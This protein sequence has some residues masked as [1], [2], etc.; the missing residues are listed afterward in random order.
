MRSRE[1]LCAA[2]VTDDR[3]LTIVADLLGE[4]TYGLS[5]VRVEAVDY[6]LQ[7]ITTAGRWWV[8]GLAR[9][10]IGDLP[11]R[12]FV[13]YVQNWSRSP[14]FA[15]VPP[16]IREMAAASVPWRTEAGVY[17]SDLAHRLPDGLS[18]PRALAVID[19]DAL[20]STIWLEEVPL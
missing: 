20:S 13:K 3:L 19:V 8:S 9:T 12:I 6:D 11:F 1:L 5:D 17:R 16:E 18:M 4:E 7:S 15:R 10:A 2:D 14:Q